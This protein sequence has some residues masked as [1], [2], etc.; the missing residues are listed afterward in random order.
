M[1]ID[2]TLLFGK[3]ELQLERLE[4]E[5]DHISLFV[6]TAAATA[7]CPICGWISDRVHSSYT[8]TVCDLPWHGRPVILRLRIR[9]FFCEH[10]GCRRVIFA[11]RIP[12]VAGDYA[13]KTDRLE[14]ALLAVGLALGGEAG[15]RLAVE[16]GL[17][18]S[19]DTLLRRIRSA[20]L[21]DAS[22]VRV[23]GVDDW[24]FRRG[25]NSGTILVDL[26]CHRPIDLLEGS[27]ASPLA[28]WLNSHPEVEFICRDRG[29]AYADAARQGAPQAVQILDR[30]HLLKNLSET[31]ERFMDSHRSLVEQA[32]SNVEGK[33]MIDESLAVCSET[34]LSSKE[35]AEKQLNRQKRY[36]RYLKVIE[37]H[38]QGLS[39]RAISRTLSINRGTVRKF[40]HSDG[41]P[42]RGQKKRTGSILDP[43]IPYI[44][45]RWAEGCDNAHQLWRELQ[46]RGYEGKV[47]MVRRY[48]RRLR[49]RLAE[50]TPQQQARFLSTKEAFKAPTSRRA[51]GWLERDSEELTET[52][53]AFVERLKELC[54]AAGKVR[55]LTRWFR[56][57][58]KERCSAQLDDWLDGAE[59]STVAELKSF[60]HSLK[61]E[62]EA[63]RAA[64]SYEWSQGQ[65]EGQITRLKL[66]KRQMYGRANFDLLK[67]RVLAAA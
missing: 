11:E 43:Y 35:D 29:G 66:I 52:Q 27:Q 16:L 51:G 19:P 55:K 28:E 21:P 5:G 63:V 37:L 6:T 12:E 26:E 32:A 65:V 62:Y 22:K 10:D 15:S 45:L 9:R 44:H 50:L 30:W 48:A 40:L 64:L 60:A 14:S 3:E 25:S 61:K 42:E 34:M 39:E 53:R 54:P 17:I 31:L 46:A 20:P 58:V 8:R 18:S 41:F 2:E 49:R 59:Q 24:A 1:Q 33:Q 23:L 4:I 13:R 47:G 38:S 36:D 56:K 7:E 57:L 67:R